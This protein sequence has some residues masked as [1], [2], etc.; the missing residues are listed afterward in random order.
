MLQYIRSARSA[1]ACDPG[2]PAARRHYTALVAAAFLAAASA[3][4]V[5]RVLEVSAPATAAPGA[6]IEVTVR[7]R[8]DAG[9][10]EHIGF[11]HVQYSADG[12]GTWTGLCFEQ[13]IG[14]EATRK[15]SIT[16][17]AEGSQTLVRARVAFR[18]GV[19]GDVD[20]RGAAI[21]WQDDWQE[22]RQPPARWA[23]THVG[24]P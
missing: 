10:G 24:A 17:G 9:A 8:T 3:R 15:F 20:F 12:G 2:R 23:T 13:K 18:G 6:R 11:L 14:T 22:W 19:A 5:E 21:S 4:G 1:S 7:A 16:T